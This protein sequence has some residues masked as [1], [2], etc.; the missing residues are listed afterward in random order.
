MSSKV[1]SEN[2]ITSYA[3]AHQHK[4]KQLIESALSLFVDNISV[5]TQRDEYK[6]LVEKDP[7]LVA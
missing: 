7:R 2:A 3:F 6:E 5:L 1:N 4:A